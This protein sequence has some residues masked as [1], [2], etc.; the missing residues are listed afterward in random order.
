[1]DGC[2]W[3]QNTSEY[4]SKCFGDSWRTFKSKWFQSSH[5]MG[6]MILADKVIVTRYPYY[7]G[8][9]GGSLHNLDA[10]LPFCNQIIILLFGPHSQ[11]PSIPNK[12]KLFLP[13]EIVICNLL[14]K[15]LC[16][17]SIIGGPMRVMMEVGRSIWWPTT[18][19]KMLGDRWWH[20]HLGMLWRTLW[21]IH[22]WC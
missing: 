6:T 2:S 8:G 3:S 16:A 1:M 4:F 5:P 21:C 18:K 17:H 7:M 19:L 20:I 14:L 15:L 13:L 22:T 11:Q 9:E 10:L 12:K